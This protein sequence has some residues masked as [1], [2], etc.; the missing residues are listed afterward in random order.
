MTH[1]EYQRIPLDD[2][3]GLDIQRAL[4][5]ERAIPKGNLPP[6]AVPGRQVADPN[7]V[8]HYDSGQ[9]APSTEGYTTPAAG[10][11]AT[12]PTV[13][14]DVTPDYYDESSA[15]FEDDD[16]AKTELVAEVV[17][18]DGEGYQAGTGYGEK[19]RSNRRVR[20]LAGALG[21]IVIGGLGGT[22]LM[23]HNGDTGISAKDL[24]SGKNNMPSLGQTPTAAP[25]KQHK[26]KHKPTQVASETPDTKPTHTP[27]TEPSTEPSAP[28]S[29]DTLPAP[30]VPPVATGPT[31]FRIGSLDLQPVSDNKDRGNQ[32]S[33]SYDVLTKHLDIAALRDVSED[34][35]DLLRAQVASSKKYSIYPT[36]YQGFAGH[37]PILVN[38][39]IFDVIDEQLLTG[40]HGPDLEMHPDAIVMLTIKVKATGEEFNVLNTTLPD[41]KT[42][43]AYKA[44]QAAATN[45]MDIVTNTGAHTG[46][47][48]YVLADMSDK[49]GRKQ[50]QNGNLVTDLSASEASCALTGLGQMTNAYELKHSD[51]STTSRECLRDPHMPADQLIMSSG[52]AQLVSYGN[53]VGPRRNGTEGNSLLEV[54]LTTTGNYTYAQPTTSNTTAAVPGA[55]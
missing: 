39:D 4:E 42:V 49:Y 2:R 33:T 16:G 53:S 1:G 26:H 20:V 3:I 48:V 47:A 36:E 21:L 7:Y 46:R 11:E 29:V 24:A 6:R 23:V 10:P 43:E 44:R 38:T 50:D 27:S 45:I 12:A 5:V 55:S 28:S 34:Q 40:T 22:Y 32:I 14:T 51:G 41:G 37:D 52:A 17:P 30:V 19:P 25:A 54:T 18:D 15:S 31:T 35:N 8:F 9:T 13:S